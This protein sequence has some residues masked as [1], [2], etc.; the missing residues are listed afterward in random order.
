MGY[1]HTIN[2]ILF[3]SLLF[4]TWSHSYY[5]NK[6]LC[7][8]AVVRSNPTCL[9][10]EIWRWIWKLTWYLTEKTRGTCITCLCMYLCWWWDCTYTFVEREL[11]SPVRLSLSAALPPVTP[12]HQTLTSCRL[13]HILQA[14]QSTLQKYNNILSTI[15]LI[16]I[17]VG[18]VIP[19]NR[20]QGIKVLHVV[21]CNPLMFLFTA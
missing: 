1:L 19:T 12:I 18:N 5:A 15:S 10:I 11:S 17:Q 14:I 20:F 6:V 9:H 16:S 13:F 8:A 2:I 21:Y 4:L 7:G 3:V